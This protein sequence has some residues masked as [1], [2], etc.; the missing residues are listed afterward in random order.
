MLPPELGK[1][2][3]KVQ[4]NIR[5]RVCIRMRTYIIYIFLTTLCRVH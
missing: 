3:A 5:A 2:D 1:A 4:K